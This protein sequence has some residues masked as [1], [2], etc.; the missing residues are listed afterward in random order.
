MAATSAV[1]ISHPVEGR[2]KGE[3][4]FRMPVLT[5]TICE[6]RLTGGI[7]AFFSRHLKLHFPCKVFF[8]FY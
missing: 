1:D 7:E 4:V 3:A 2:D 5:G 6:N 8:I